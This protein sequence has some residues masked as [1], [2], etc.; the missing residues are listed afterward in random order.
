[1]SSKKWTNKSNMKKWMKTN[2]DKKWIKTNMDKKWKWTAWMVKR[3]AMK[4]SSLMMKTT[5]A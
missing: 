3:M 5:Q 4:T 1:M 2:M